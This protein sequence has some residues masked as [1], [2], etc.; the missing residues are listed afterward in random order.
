MALLRTWVHEFRIREMQGQ[1][2]LVFRRDT[3]ATVVEEFNRYNRA[4][5]FRLED[6]GIAGH[7]YSGEFDDSNLRPRSLFGRL[8]F[9]CERARDYVASTV[10]VLWSRVI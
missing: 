3:L 4:P 2:R 5:Q 7:H 8:D 1:R 9:I 6:A 10:V